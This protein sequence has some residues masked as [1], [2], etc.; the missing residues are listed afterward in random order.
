MF[1][2]L[3]NEVRN[4]TGCLHTYTIYCIFNIHIHNEDKYFNEWKKKEKE[5]KRP[6]LL[7]IGKK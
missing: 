6:M 5:K 2:S 1:H 7:D 3:V 4:K